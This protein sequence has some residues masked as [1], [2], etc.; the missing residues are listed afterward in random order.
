MN[1]IRI[2]LPREKF[3]ALRGKDIASL[4]HESLPRVEDTLKAEREEVLLERTAKLEEKLMEME[5]E[6]EELREFYE[7]ALRDK[8]FMMAERGRLRKENTA[9]RAKVEEK[10]RELEKVHGS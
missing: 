4:L 5:G 6:I 8:E 2:V 3:K 9:L 7:K 1:K 10:R